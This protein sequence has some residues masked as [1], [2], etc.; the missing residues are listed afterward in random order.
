M[1]HLNSI[2]QIFYS[3]C[4]IIK[5]LRGCYTPCREKKKKRD[6]GRKCREITL[7]RQAATKYRS[8]SGWAGCWPALKMSN[9]GQLGK[10]NRET[11]LYSSWI[12]AWV[13]TA[14]SLSAWKAH[15]NAREKS[16]CHQN[17]LSAY[18]VLALEMQKED[19]ILSP[20]RSPHDTKR[21][22]LS[23]RRLWMLPG[24]AKAGLASPMFKM[25]WKMGRIH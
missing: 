14:C 6:K 7:P 8:R 12:H 17:V 11:T 24:S 9:S 23:P 20:A 1:T 15:K 22:V 2:I 19:R 10:A 25:P 4:N 5:L 16:F 13:P 21:P 18:Y 3:S